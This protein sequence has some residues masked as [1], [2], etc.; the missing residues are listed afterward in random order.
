MV[1]EEGVENKAWIIKPSGIGFF[2]LIRITIRIGF[3]GD[4]I[5]SQAAAVGG[6]ESF[7]LNN[8]QF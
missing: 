6:D 5:Q 1:S 8:P 3:F 7:P 4:P 2:S